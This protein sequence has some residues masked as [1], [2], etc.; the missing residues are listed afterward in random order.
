M[1]CFMKKLIPR[2]FIYRQRVKQLTERGW[3]VNLAGGVTDR[4]CM[5]IISKK[6]LIQMTEEEFARIK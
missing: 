1:R 3:Y 6:D 2:F 5:R 4:H